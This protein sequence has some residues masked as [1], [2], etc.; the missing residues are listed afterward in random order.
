VAAIFPPDAPEDALDQYVR[1]IAD[2]VGLKD[3]KVVVDKEPPGEGNLGEARTTYGR[4]VLHIRLAEHDSAEELRNTV[5][6]ELLHAQLEPVSWGINNAQRAL[7]EGAFS[8]FRASFEDNM[9]L[10]VDAIATAWSET[11]PLPGDHAVTKRKK[12]A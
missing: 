9:E 8:V 2:R 5:I 7:G 1:D 10:A 3:W 11:M 12:V 4:K 6:H